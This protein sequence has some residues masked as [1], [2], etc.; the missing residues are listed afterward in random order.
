MAEL[1]S[2]WITPVSLFEAQ[3]YFVKALSH[4]LKA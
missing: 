4:Y 3:S 2:F 1:L